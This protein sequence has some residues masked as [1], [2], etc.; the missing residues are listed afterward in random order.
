MCAFEIFGARRPA[1]PPPKW[2]RYRLIKD[3]S[4]DGIIAHLSHVH[5]ENVHEMDVVTITTRHVGPVQR[6]IA[7]FGHEKF[8]S[9]DNEPGQWICW[10]FRENRIRSTSYT[11]VSRWARSWILEPS[12]DRVTW[13]EIDRR[14]NT[15]VAYRPRS[16]SVSDSVECRFIR[17]MET[18]KNHSGTYVLDFRPVEFFGPLLE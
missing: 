7:D 16:F 8:D 11:V 14:E 10:D 13:K 18:D 15:L 2:I 6:D 4:L 17:L 12:M 5:G 3:G 9:S 1:P